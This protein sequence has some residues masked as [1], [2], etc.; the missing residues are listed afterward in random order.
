MSKFK[1]QLNFIRED[2]T[3]GAFLVQD[4]SGLTWKLQPNESAGVKGVKL[5]HTRVIVSDLKQSLSMYTH[6]LGLRFSNTETKKVLLQ[7]RNGKWLTTQADIYS[8][9]SESGQQVELCKYRDLIPLPN[10]RRKLNSTGL[11]HIAF[12]SDDA[13][14]LYSKLSKFACTPLSEPQTI[15]MGPNK[16]GVVFYFFDPDGVSLEVLQTPTLR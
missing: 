16:G 5:S 10:P 7:D 14:S 9:E 3:E 12:Y 2:E 6:L 4:G 15:P 8:L 13:L 1:L 11:H